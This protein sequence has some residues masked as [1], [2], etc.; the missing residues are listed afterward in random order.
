[1]FCIDYINKHDCDVFTTLNILA[2]DYYHAMYVH[3]SRPG[4]SSTSIM[5]LGDL[6]YGYPVELEHTPAVDAMVEEI[7]SIPVD[8]YKKDYDRS[9]GILLNLFQRTIEKR[10]VWGAKIF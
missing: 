5:I 2:G 7:Y 10:L 4:I 9:L 6:K 8:L 1:M 3:P